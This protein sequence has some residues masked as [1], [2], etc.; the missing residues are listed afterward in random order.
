MDITCKTT[1]ISTIEPKSM[2][3]DQNLYI[4][5]A[6]MDGRVEGSGNRR[7]LCCIYFEIRMNMGLLT[8]EHRRVFIVTLRNFKDC[9]DLYFIESQERIF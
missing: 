5:T 4:F 9:K 6:F 2:I 8:D 1:I 7:G 3:I